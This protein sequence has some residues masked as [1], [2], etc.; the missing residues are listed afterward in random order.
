MSLNEESVSN[1]EQ[2]EESRSGHTHTDSCY[3]LAFNC[4]YVEHSHNNQCYTRGV[5][6]CSMSEHSHTDSCTEPVLI[7]GY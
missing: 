5:L 3:S 1:L 2:P 4:G 7:C 6:T